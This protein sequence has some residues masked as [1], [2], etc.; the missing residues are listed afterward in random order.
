MP[1]KQRGGAHFG[2]ELRDA[3][4]PP[5]A[6]R[7]GATSLSRRATHRH[8]VEGEHHGEQVHHAFDSHHVAVVEE[9]IRREREQGRRQRDS[10]LAGEPAQRKKRQ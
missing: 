2:V 6:G 7:G 9:R 4:P 8:A 5:A 1:T 3:A 10:A